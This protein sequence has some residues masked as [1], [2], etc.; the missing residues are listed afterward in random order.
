MHL[1]AILVLENLGTNHG[2]AK[3]RVTVATLPSRYRSRRVYCNPKFVSM[4]LAWQDL[5]S[6]DHRR[7]S[8]QRRCSLLGAIQGFV[9]AAVAARVHPFHVHKFLYLE[10]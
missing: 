10:R 6:K 2:L 4:L 5:T 3:Q 9:I 7:W 8:I 1:W